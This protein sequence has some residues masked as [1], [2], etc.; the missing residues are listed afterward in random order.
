MDVRVTHPT[1]A[2]QMNKPLTQIYKD[3]EREK[4]ALYN[5]RVIN[6]EK[7]SFTPLIFTT[8]GGMGPECVRMNKRIAERISLKRGELYSDVM[9]HIRTRL[10]FALLRCTVIAVR[11]IRGS[12][13]EKAE[14]E[15]SEIS[16]NL[17]PQG[18]EM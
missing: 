16:F 9:R 15:L 12:M 5:D 2:S 14:E 6:T 1:A 4:K 8:T 13:K 10:R 7:S 3:H 11:G 18:K 17:I